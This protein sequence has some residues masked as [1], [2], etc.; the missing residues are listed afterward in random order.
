LWNPQRSSTW[1]PNKPVHTAIELREIGLAAGLTAVGFTHAEPFTEAR[2]TLE[3]RK[4]AGLHGGMQFTYRNPERSTTPTRILESAQSLIVG[5]WPYR[6]PGD[7]ASPST[8]SLDPDDRPQ[9]EIA[10]YAWRDHYTSLKAALGEMATALQEDGY[11]ARVVADDN[12]LVDRAAAV[13]AGIGWAGKNSNVLVPGHGS[14]FVLGAVVTDAPLDHDQPVEPACGSCRRCLDGCPTNAII[15]DGVV[16]AR[17][18]LA[19]L[20]QAGG[21]FP[22]EFREALGTRIYGCDD[23]Q[24]V[25]PPSRGTDVAMVGDEVTSLDL[26]ELLT[27]DDEALLAAVGRWYIPKRDLRYV[28]RNALVA[29][30][31]TDVQGD[32]RAEAMDVLASYIGSDDMLSEHARW[33]ADQLDSSTR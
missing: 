27:L 7:L 30:G 14:W 5:A 24:I 20:L 16:D 19:W 22:I 1:Q 11:T 23:C 32:A 10:A 4:A 18:C 25:C 31:N 6:A 9:A 21:D 17:R 29:L 3:T 8:A 28:R 33:A 2:V 12:A 15:A 13:R 26:L